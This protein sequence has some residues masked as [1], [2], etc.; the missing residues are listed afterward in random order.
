M[1]AVPPFIL[2]LRLE[3]DLFGPL[4]ALRRAHFP[5][6]RNHVPA[7]VTLF[8]A[9]PGD[10]EVR[11]KRDLEAV[12]TACSGFELHLPRVRRWGKGVF[13]PV[14]SSGLLALRAAL[15]VQWDD[16]L[17][18]QDR[19]PYRPHV[20]LQNKV[21]EATARALYETLAPAWVPL[22]GQ[23]TGLELWRYL[24]GPWGFVASFEFGG[25]R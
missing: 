16:L 1:K 8:H 12:C 18:P 2:T 3:A 19:R 13:A 7:H 5:P 4:D 10:H 21:S 17:T 20:T 9:L 14:E 22:K 25:Q 23:A 11:L 6:E 24:G 15:A